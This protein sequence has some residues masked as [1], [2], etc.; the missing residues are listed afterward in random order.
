M[1]K[2]SSGC[3]RVIFAVAAILAFA[4]VIHAQVI[5]PARPPSGMVFHRIEGR[6]RQR[7]QKVDN[8]RVRLIRFPQM[9][10]IGETFTNQD[11]Q[12]VFQRIPTGDYI[13]E[14]VETEVYEAT[15]T[16]V[17]VYPREALEPRPMSATL[18]ID[19]PL[20]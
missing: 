10:P 17:A 11:G 2:T 4:Q 1:K 20:Q 8:L 13:V 16:N 12:F 6:L 18:F 9:Q 7:G 14:T 3:S 15:E 5:G 19:L